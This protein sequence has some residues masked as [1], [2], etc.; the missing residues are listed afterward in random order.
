[1]GNFEDLENSFKAKE[2]KIQQ[3]LKG[4]KEKNPSFS[5]LK[6]I[7]NEIYHYQSSIIL[8]VKRKHCLTD[9]TMQWLN[10]VTW[11]A[12]TNPTKHSPLNIKDKWTNDLN[13][14]ITEQNTQI[15]LQV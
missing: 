3:K 15:S 5:K 1:M 10:F 4:I 14:Q 12:L 6:L 7:Y 11:K 8:P 9:M 2:N 13:R